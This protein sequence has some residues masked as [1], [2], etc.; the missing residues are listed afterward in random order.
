MLASSNK[1]T[2]NR[3]IEK[4]QSMK[5][6]EAYSFRQAKRENP[7]SSCNAEVSEGARKKA[8]LRPRT[9]KVRILC[10]HREKNPTERWGRSTPPDLDL[11]GKKYRSTANTTPWMAPKT[12]NVQFAPCQRP[13]RTIVMKR[14]HAAF[15]WPCALPPRGMYK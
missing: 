13:A 12:I 5:N 4:R 7:E 2:T 8:R 14:L 3:R 15:H 11:A 1:S 10:A 9:L 6:A